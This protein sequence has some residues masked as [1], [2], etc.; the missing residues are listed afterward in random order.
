MKKS[1]KKLA[2]SKRPKKSPEF[3]EPKP[4]DYL[5]EFH[6]R[7]ILSFDVDWIVLQIGAEDLRPA[8]FRKMLMLLLMGWIFC[9]TKPSIRKSLAWHYA[10]EQIHQSVLKINEQHKLNSYFLSML[11]GLGTHSFGIRWVYRSLGGLSSKT[12]KSWKDL[13]VAIAK[14]ATRAES[15]LF[16]FDVMVVAGAYK[17]GTRKKANLSLTK[18]KQILQGWQIDRLGDAEVFDKENHKQTAQSKASL[19][20]RF[21]EEYQKLFRKGTS[22]KSQ[23]ISLSSFSATFPEFENGYEFVAAFHSMRVYEHWKPIKVARKW[24]A[25]KDS[26]ALDYVMRGALDRLPLGNREFQLQF[27]GR[28]KTF[29]TFIQNR[30]SID[31]NARFAP[32]SSVEAQL[33]I[34][35]QGSLEGHS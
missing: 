9:P 28:A 12:K 1:K 8:W 21:S 34:Y 10:N 29:S 6:Q 26:S 18:A 14:A 19:K 33:N 25:P 16:L 3:V 35:E 30:A 20:K 27:L 7:C 15:C 13:S 31:N 11:G 22:F 4:A 32:I 24:R 23:A 2:P 5:L 17:H